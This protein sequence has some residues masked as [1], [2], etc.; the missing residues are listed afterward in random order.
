MSKWYAFILLTCAGGWQMVLDQQHRI[1]LDKIFI[2][3]TALLGY[4]LL[5]GI[6]CGMPK[7]DIAIYIS[8]VAV[9]MLFKRNID[10]THILNLFFLTIAALQAI[11]A[12]LQ[13][14]MIVPTRD[15]FNV[16]GSYNNPAGLAAG[17][18][19]VFPLIFIYWPKLKILSILFI[20]VSTI[21]ILL[22]GSRAGLLSIIIVSIIYFFDHLPAKSPRFKK[23]IIVLVTITLTVSC[24][25]LFFLKEQSAIGRILIWKVTSCMITENLFWGAGSY[26][27]L[28]N[29]MLSQAEY[30][31]KNTDD[32]YAML[33]STIMHPFNEY[34]LL[35]SKYG[36]VGLSFIFYAFLYLIKRVRISSP[37]MLC[38]ICIC[39]FSLFSYPFQ[40]PFTS[41][42]LLY[43][44]SQILGADQQSVRFGKIWSK[45]LLSSL[46]LIAGFYVLQDISFEYKWNK[47]AQLSLAGQTSA[48]RPYFTELEEEWNGNPLFLY[49]YA[50]ELHHLG[51]P[52]KS[53]D[54]LKKT[55]IYWND[56]DIEMLFADNY[57][58]LE[59]WTAAE[60]HLKSAS[61]MCPN[62]FLP[63]FYLHEIYVKTGRTE[64]A[65]EIAY[66][67]I[68]KKAKIPSS[69]VSFIRA[70]MRRYVSAD[71]N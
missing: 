8:L 7:I 38:I 52:T 64:K 69:T 46:L 13:Y 50:A 25:Y 11:Y 1:A 33:A 20:A 55:N 16:L 10:Q 62:R 30:F 22:S 3:L 12:L 27:F 68:N 26:G 66:L 65:M 24:I 5:R 70:Q 9:Y 6:L 32:N 29:Y 71:N 56:Y 4:F 34:L 44:I 61:N 28:K 48:M 53:L 42:A 35:I 2:A 41:I 59:D 40:Y 45:L 63:L 60:K 43:S 36:I 49:N 57:R 14:T 21:A 47:T 39:I 37:Y 23:I 31:T 18:S 51:E 54:I 19:C 17:L 58:Q 15:T 67:V